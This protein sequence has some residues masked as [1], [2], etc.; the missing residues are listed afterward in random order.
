MSQAPGKLQQLI[1][2]FS[3]K[4][5]RGGKLSVSCLSFILQMV[6]CKPLWRRIRVDWKLK[7]ISHLDIS[8][9]PQGRNS[10]WK[11]LPLR[12]HVQSKGMNGKLWDLENFY[13]NI[14]KSC[15][16]RACLYIN[17]LFISK[18]ELL[19]LVRLKEYFYGP[20]KRFLGRR[21]IVGGHSE[22]IARHI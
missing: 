19:V 8:Q 12:T 20:C 14:P 1:S 2:R 13:L 18:L 5:K 4:A 3:A 15:F 22:N 16:S 6:E 21:S 10:F 11:F 9:A 17:P 7:Y